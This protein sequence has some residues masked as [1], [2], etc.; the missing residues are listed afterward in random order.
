MNI[1]L[2]TRIPLEPGKIYFMVDGESEYQYAPC[3]MC[4]GTG[5][6]EIKGKGIKIRCPECGGEDSMKYRTVGTVQK[7]RVAKY[8]LRS[9]YFDGDGRVIS[10]RFVRTDKEGGYGETLYT[11]E[12]LNNLPKMEIWGEPLSEDYGAV[13]K[14]VKRKNKLERERI[15]DE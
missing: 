5:K 9:I 10:A 2:N 6:V 14:E 1:G 3:D 11:G 13:L 7:F 4:D 15:K 8:C 12:E